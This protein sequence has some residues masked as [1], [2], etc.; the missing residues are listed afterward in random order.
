MAMT[1]GM[2][3]EM[4]TGMEIEMQTS[5]EMSIEM[6]GGDTIYQNADHLTKSEWDP[7]LLLE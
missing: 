2:E 6:D 5:T 1:T 3:M 4:S 7:I